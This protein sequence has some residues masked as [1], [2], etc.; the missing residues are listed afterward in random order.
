MLTELVPLLLSAPE[1]VATYKNCFSGDTSIPI[2]EHINF[3]I[4]SVDVFNEILFNTMRCD[5]H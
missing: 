2:V 3:L 5:Q 1:V 4:S